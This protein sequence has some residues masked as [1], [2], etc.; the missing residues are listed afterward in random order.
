MGGVLDRR[1]CFP[2]TIFGAE[3]HIPWMRDCLAVLLNS[4]CDQ[5]LA[6]VEFVGAMIGGQGL[7]GDRTTQRM[8]RTSDVEH[9][10]VQQ[11]HF[12]SRRA[13]QQA[14][15]EISF[16]ALIHGGEACEICIA[17]TRFP[18]QRI[19]AVDVRCDPATVIWRR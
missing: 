5:S 16:T 15:H 11:I 17:F 3:R 9:R 6:G 1:E 18:S 7:R 12:P 8:F 2:L 10:E 14:D 4:D 13:S 19:A